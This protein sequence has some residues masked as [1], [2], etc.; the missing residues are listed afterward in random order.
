M[1]RCA[2]STAEDLYP[3]YITIHNGNDSDSIW[4]PKDIQDLEKV[5]VDRLNVLRNHVHE[6]SW[7]VDGGCLIGAI[8][9]Q[10]DKW[11][12]DHCDEIKLHL[13]YGDTRFA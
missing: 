3:L 12:G 4:M 2:S 8:E 1:I 10:D 11:G 7:F 13:S 6:E 5:I 9:P